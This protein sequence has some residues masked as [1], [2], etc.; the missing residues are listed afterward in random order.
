MPLRKLSSHWPLRL[1]AF[2]SLLAPALFFAFSTWQTARTMDAQAEER[3]ARGLDVVHEHALTALQTVERAIAEINEVLRGLTDAE[4]RARESELFLRFKR[5]QQSLSQI[6]AIWAF[7]SDGHPLIS[8][9]IFPVPQDLNNSDRTYF[10]AQK[11]SD[12]GIF[13]SEVVQAKVGS[14]HFFVVSGRR[15]GV[16]PGRFA[17]VIGVTVMP[18]HFQ[19]FYR[20]LSRGRDSFALVRTDG[21]LLARFPETRVENFSRRSNAIGGPGQTAD[22]VRFVATS[23]IDGIE[24]RGG[25]RRVHGFPL[26]VQSGIE[27]AALSA[28][29]WSTTLTQLALIVPVS[30]TMFLLALFALRRLQR[31]EEATAQRETA[32]AAL[33]QSQRLEAVGQMTGGVAHD[34]NNLL[35]IVEGNVQR[36]R[37]AVTDETVPRRYFDAVET[38]VK[39]GTALTRQ[40][41]S[42]SRRQTH[43]AKVIDLRQR[44]PVIQ[45]MLQASLRSDISVTTVVQ[46]GGWRIKADESELELSLL[47]LA[48]NARDAMSSG[49]RLTLAA[50][51]VAFNAPNDLSL[52]GEFV[53]V[54]VTDTGSGIPPDVLGRVFEPFFTTKEFGKGTGLGM[55]QVYGFAKQSGG[56]AAVTSELGKGTKVTLYLPRTNESALAVDDV[57]VPRE[58]QADDGRVLLVEDNPEVAEVTRDLLNDVGYQS[59][60]ASDVLAALRMLREHK[61][62]IVLTDIVM[63]GGKSGVDLARWIRSTHGGKL[64]VILA[65][66]YS[67]RTADASAEGFVILRKPYTRN[68]LA[69]ALSAA[70]SDV[71]KQAAT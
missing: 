46:P 40:L 56:M 67:E 17:G 62:D 30:L 54:S 63:P 8:S 66:G 70:R 55:S 49:G 34:F 37:R 38:A 21:T 52:L 13:I 61:V 42:F 68:D 50:E 7:D 58:T 6:E 33:K 51:N 64:P 3:I 12:S 43:E 36:I 47:N 10:A 39:R 4:I 65:T 57:D 15:E 45:Q 35:M 14:L 29:F 9:T 53:A 69:D 22:E 23:P 31:F 41:L 5:T 18:E 20:K 27:T 19:E 24:R 16:Q 1:I 44:L 2:L 59:F 26:Y 48:V 11:N 60:W 28:E 32:E 71:S 25:F